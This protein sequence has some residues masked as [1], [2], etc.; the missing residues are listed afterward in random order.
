MQYVFPSLLPQRAPLSGKYLQSRPMNRNGEKSALSSFPLPVNKAPLTSYNG[1]LGCNEKALEIRLTHPL[2]TRRL[3]QWCFPCAKD[4]GLNTRHVLV[5]T[6]DTSWL[7][8]ET[9]LGH[10]MRHETRDTSWLRYET[11]LGYDMRHALGHDPRHVSR[12]E[13]CFGHHTRHVLVTTRD[14]SYDT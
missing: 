14:T 2:N 3:I 12:H 10:D 4:L 1:S 5:T 13:T 7:R 6:R 11:L 8:H 9:R